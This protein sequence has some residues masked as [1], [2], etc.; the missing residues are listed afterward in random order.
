MIKA[1]RIDTVRGRLTA[2]YITALAAALII[3]GGL[4]YILL[5]RALY[6]RID[7]NLY[8]L[9]QITRT[10]LTNDLDEG[11]DQADAARS[12]AAELSS[13]QLMLAIYDEAG[14][15]LAEGGRD[16][17]LPIPLPAL[18]TIPQDTALLQTVAETKDADDRHRLAF[19]RVIIPAHRIGFVV[20]AGSS[21]EPTDEELE[22]L[23]EILAYV[24]P[25][26]LVL[27][28][29]GG[30]FLARQSLSPVAAMA[31]RARRMGAEDLSGRL[32]VAN[33]R[34]ELGRL[35]ETFN[36]LLARL[37]ESITTQRQSTAAQRQFMADASHELRTP[38]TTT[39][40]AAN[41]ALQQPHRE[42][43]EYRDTLAIIE[44]QATRLSRIV[45]DMFTLARADAGTYPVL[46]TPM[47]LDEV[48]DDV[49]KAARVL[50]SARDVSIEAT[51]IRSA[52]LTGDE[53]LIRRL[54]VN[55]LDNAVRYSPPGSTVHVELEQ[56]PGG[57]TL[58]VSDQG[59]GIPAEAQPHIF[60]RFYRADTAR[61]R[62]GGG[63]GGA[64]LGLALSR[65]IA[66][67]HGGQLTLARSSEAGTTFTAF[68][69]NS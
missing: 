10:S 27:A 54:M 37:E 11:Q 65:W 50:A 38:V 55:L 15:L 45:D 20:V 17:D 58:S 36:D 44:Q 41:V 42:E 25:I 5:A 53:D 66:E 28:G 2:F 43:S 67:V 9:V 62:R 6:A 48:V 68:L 46:N 23:R 12:T 16:S 14:R 3:V 29:V 13:R 60:E 30:W 40:T 19:R 35:A 39:R 32:P 59:P 26:A 69:P 57:Y 34:D 33:P 61:A 8:A 31:D 18:N 1:L 63:H 56:A 4:I 7:D 49:V 51:T 47:Y 24:V 64:G 22:S 21:L 52:V